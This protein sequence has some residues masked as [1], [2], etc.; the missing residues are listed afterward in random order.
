VISA[1]NYTDIT[2]TGATITW[3]T[4]E[5]AT[6]QIEYG[7]TEEYGSSTTL[8]TNLVTS[9]SEELTGL[10][11]GKTYHYR[12]ISK[13]AANNQAASADATFTTAASYGG[14]P[15]WAWVIIALAGVAGLGAAAFIVKGRL[16]R[17]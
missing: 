12:V 10:K 1:A 11:A 4:S 13:D 16:A 14:V 3:T 17:K 6:S 9:H 15:V 7:L 8:D 2:K 5:N